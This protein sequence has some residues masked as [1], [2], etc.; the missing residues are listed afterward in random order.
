MHGRYTFFSKGSN[1]GK[2]WG[3]VFNNF[4]PFDGKGNTDPEKMDSEM[5]RVRQDLLKTWKR[6]KGGHNM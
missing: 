5:E 4:N 1:E 6:S 2:S 3:Y